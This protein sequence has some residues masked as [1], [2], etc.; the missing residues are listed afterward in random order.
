LGRDRLRLLR[1]PLGLLAFMIP[2]PAA[3]LTGLETLSQYGSAAVANGLFTLSG[4][5]VLQDGLIF[6]LPGQISFQVAPECSGLHSTVVLLITSLVAGHLMLRS[7]W[8]R[9]LLVL[10]VVP[11]AL[12]RNGFRIYVIGRLC[13]HYGPGMFQHWIHR[14]GGPVFFVLSL[15]PFFGLLIWLIKTERR[16]ERRHPASTTPS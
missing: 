16:G 4:I 12:L 3:V 1:F 14:R 11:L 2:L 8:K 5:P 10:V 15:V 9:A 7:W 13:I 6:R